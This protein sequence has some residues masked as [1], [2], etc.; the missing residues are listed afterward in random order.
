MTSTTIIERV[1]TALCSDN[2]KLAEGLCDLDKIISVGWSAKKAKLGALGMWARYVHDP[3][4]TREFLDSVHRL[5]I[6]LSR[7]RK[8][9]G[10]QDELKRLS[11]AV[12]FWW[13]TSECVSCQ[14]RGLIVLAESQVVSDF[15]CEQCNGSG[16]RSAPHAS[17][18]RLEWDERQFQYRFNELLT[19]I[20]NGFSEFAK[21]C[22]RYNAKIANH[23]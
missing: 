20:E 6:S 5:A 8:R 12:V 3:Q 19:H 22:W 13:I 15:V 1:A 7:Q 11:E 17:E 16:K 14:G 9:G 23:N 10:S 4:R 2:L 18:A 21:L